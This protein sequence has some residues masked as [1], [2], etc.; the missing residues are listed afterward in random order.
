MDLVCSAA[1]LSLDETVRSL[2]SPS[3]FL[4]LDYAELPP[5]CILRCT[6]FL[7][8]PAKFC[9][10]ERSSNPFFSPLFFFCWCRAG[11][12]FA[13]HYSSGDSLTNMQKPQGPNCLDRRVT[14]GGNLLAPDP[15]CL[16]Q[17]GC[18][19]KRVMRQYMLLFLNFYCAWWKLPNTQNKERKPG[20][21]L[22]HRVFLRQNRKV[23]RRR[24]ERLY[25]GRRAD[26]SELP[27][28]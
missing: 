26:S 10:S 5:S 22:T 8:F 11:L 1:S 28:I 20:P 23:E 18:S 25:S 12:C 15:Q 21:V 16:H 7:K 4:P 2:I 3:Q 14:R 27:L 13:K 24:G 17:A 19:N 6:Y 9:S